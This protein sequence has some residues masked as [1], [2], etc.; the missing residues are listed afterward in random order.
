M[1]KQKEFVKILKWT[2]YENIMIFMFKA[3]HYCYLMYLRTLEICVLKH[4]SLILKN[5][6]PILAQQAALQKIKV[7]L[8][9]LTD[10]DMLL[11][12]EKA[13]RVGICQKIRTNT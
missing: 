5:S 13:I 3:I 9:L 7:K 2:M 4:V 12:I 11:M 10:I 6:A 8:G 1:R